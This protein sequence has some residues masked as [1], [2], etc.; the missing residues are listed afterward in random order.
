[1][2]TAPKKR[3]GDG[4]EERRKTQNRDGR[5]S[6]SWSLFGGRRGHLYSFI[7]RGAER[8][9]RLRPFFNEARSGAAIRA[10]LF[11][12]ARSGAAACGLFFNETLFVL[13]FINRC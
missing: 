1:M 12:E 8:N 13:L 7:Q 10:F 6:P 3:G 11:N 4:A 5:G 9:D 2:C